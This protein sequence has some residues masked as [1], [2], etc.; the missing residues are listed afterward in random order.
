MIANNA[1]TM[2][3]QDRFFAVALLAFFALAA[4][5]INLR[6]WSDDAMF[7]KATTKIGL[8]DFLVERYT[9]W[10]GRLGIEA[11]LFTTIR[12]SFVWKTAIPITMLLIAYSFWHLFLASRGISPYMGGGLALASLFLISPAVL[13]AAVWYVTGAYYYLLP[14]SMGLFVFVVFHRGQDSRPIETAVAAIFALVAGS[15]E[16]VG[17]CLLGA[18]AMTYALD[19]R[20]GTTRVVLGVVTLATFVAL[21]FAP[22]NYLRLVSEYIY[23]P[24]FGDYNVLRKLANGLYV[25]AVHFAA[26]ENLASKALMITIAIGAL[27]RDFRFKYP[28]IALAVIGAM[29]GNVLSFSPLFQSSPATLSTYHFGFDTLRYFLILMVLLSLSSAFYLLV[30]IYGPCRR[31]LVAAAMLG[32]QA[33]ITVLI[34]FSPTVFESGQRIFLISDLLGLMLMWLLIGDTSVAR[35][36]SSRD[37]PR[38][39][40]E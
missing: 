6:E 32:A 29:L 16:Q 25:Y 26:P 33:A 20:L 38:W 24:E 34:G 7:L 17:L 40:D 21:I 23:L 10:S 31:F 13:N 27:G 15:S 2:R 39:T 8:Y 3:P 1:F 36:P 19:R 22:G 30:N 35:F 5:G 4:Y 28:M 11:L 14:A 37:T 12:F 18:M 9:T